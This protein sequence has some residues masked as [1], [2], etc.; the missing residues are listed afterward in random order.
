MSMCLHSLSHL[1]IVCSNGRNFVKL[2]MYIMPLKTKVFY[3][4]YFPI[5]NTNMAAVRNSEVAVTSAG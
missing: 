4:L 5:N 3:I 2:V 1:H